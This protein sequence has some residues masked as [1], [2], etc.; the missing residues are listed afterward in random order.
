[1]PDMSRSLIYW[2]IAI[3]GLCCALLGGMLAGTV[4]LAQSNP[5][6]IPRQRVPDATI[7]L[8]GNDVTRGPPPPPE[9]PFVPPPTSLAPP[10]ERVPQVAPLAPRA[11]Q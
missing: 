1:M 2:R 3:R 4:A 6:A 10:M 9:R 11:G 5:S 7:M 8:N